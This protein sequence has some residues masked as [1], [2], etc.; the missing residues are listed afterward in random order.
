MIRQL[1]VLSVLLSNIDFGYSQEPERLPA[2][3]A[4]TALAEHLQVLAKAH[5]GKVSI[6][7]RHLDSKE[8]FFFNEAATMPTASL[9]KLPI[10]VEAYLQRNENKVDF[11]K[12]ITVTKEDMV[13]GSGILTAHFSPGIT[14]KLRDAIHLMIVYSDN[15]ATN[16]V[17]DQIGIAK[18]NKRMTSM[19]F[20]E[21]RIN[22]KV[23]KGSITSVDPERTKVWGL[24]STTAKDMI[25]L[26][27]MIHENKI[28]DKANCE[29]M[30][31][32][33]FKCDAKEIFPR[34]L[35][36]S[37]KVAHKTGAVN[38]SRTSAG[39]LYFKEG[40]PVA[41]CVLTSENED[42][43][44]THENAG[45]IICAKVAKEVYDYFHQKKK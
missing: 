33:L 24:G 29:E 35:P 17:L 3:H 12:P 16:L 44:W 18:V 42:Q 4:V 22:A 39:I 7:V 23:F 30:K 6:A 8:E 13:Q 40:G 25:D 37:V 15:T 20:P 31:T 5:K 36:A 21:T 27:Q 43:R 10:M 9:I 45:E 34:Y 38:Q 14:I 2:P 41:L 32:H 26:L 1:I 11:D 19:G 28:I